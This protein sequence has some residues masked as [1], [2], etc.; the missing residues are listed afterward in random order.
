M[1]GVIDECET[2]FE[3]HMKVTREWEAP[4][5]TQAL[6]RG[7]VERRSRQLGHRRS[8]TDLNRDDVRL[9]QGGEPTFVSIDDRDGAEWN[10]EALGP[11]KR[12]LVGRPA[13]AS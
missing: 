12:L 4:R 6:H 11:T 7:A 1:T 3:H 8:T 9:T 13:G 5:V 2:T 10:T